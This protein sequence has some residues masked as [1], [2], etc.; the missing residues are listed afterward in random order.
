MLHLGSRTFD[1]GRDDLHTADK[2]HG[3]R[4]PELALK[5]MEK[6]GRLQSHGLPGTTLLCDR[7]NITDSI[8]NDECCVVTDGPRCV[9]AR[10]RR[11]ITA[12]KRSTAILWQH[13]AFKAVLIPGKRPNLCENF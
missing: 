11:R 7:E 13:I 3:M 8:F 6:L 10:R 9:H 12:K 1:N 5:S 4:M 2:A